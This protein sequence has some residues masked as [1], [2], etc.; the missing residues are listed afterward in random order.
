MMTSP[1]QE[2]CNKGL[3]VD[4]VSGNNKN[5]VIVADTLVNYN[6]PEGPW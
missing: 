1:Y 6:V 4:S 2:L 5:R 3:A